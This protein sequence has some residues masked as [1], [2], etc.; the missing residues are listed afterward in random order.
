M[1]GPSIGLDETEM[2]PVGGGRRSVNGM[3]VL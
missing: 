1:P 2:M 3:K